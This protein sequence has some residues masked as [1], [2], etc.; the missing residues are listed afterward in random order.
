M[1]WLFYDH[2]PRDIEREIRRLCTASDDMRSMAPVAIARVG[3]TWYT[4]LSVTYVSVDAAV[5]SGVDRQYE[6]QDGIRFVFGAVFLTQISGGWG[7]KDLDETMGPVESCAPSEILDLLSPTRDTYARAW[8][9]R[10]RANSAMA[11]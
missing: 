7:Y 9:A 5:L 6:L 1:G 4:A 11:G 3:S 2:T 8:R 10:C